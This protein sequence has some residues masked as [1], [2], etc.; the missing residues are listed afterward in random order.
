M[1]KRR[2]YSLRSAS[3][4]VS[5]AGAITASAAF[6]QDLDRVV[7]RSGNPVVGEVEELRRGTLD[8]DTDEMG[9]VGIRMTSPF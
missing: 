7:L 3:V 6:G 5:V 9:V 4:R 1:R 2:P 8:F